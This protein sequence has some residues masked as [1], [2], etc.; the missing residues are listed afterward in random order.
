MKQSRTASD[1]VELAHPLPRDDDVAE[2][3]RHLV[4]DTPAPKTTSER[5]DRLAQKIAA[6]THLQ[7]LTAQ[8]LIY[9]EETYRSM[10]LLRAWSPL[11]VPIR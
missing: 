5:W 6:Y 10:L 2:L 8:H 7:R 3:L 1:W 4:R 9:R 11:S